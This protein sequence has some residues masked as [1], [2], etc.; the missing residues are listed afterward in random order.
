LLAA[1]VND[2]FFDPEDGG[3]LPPWCSSARL[4]GVIFQKIL[5]FDSVVVNFYYRL[6]NSSL[7]KIFSHKYND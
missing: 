1:Y 3:V 7:K 5:L 6:L 2:L 4:H